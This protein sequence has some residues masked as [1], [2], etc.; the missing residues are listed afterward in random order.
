MVEG[1]SLRCP[2][3]VSFIRFFKAVTK[4]G[5]SMP[6]KAWDPAGLASYGT[7]D[8]LT[9]RKRGVFSQKKRTLFVERLVSG[10]FRHAEV[11][12]GRVCMAASRA[13]ALVFVKIFIIRW[14]LRLVSVEDMLSVFWR[15]T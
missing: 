6:F 10:R 14:G 5:S 13:P 8:T 9:W 12:H 4:P 1:E 11:K 7:A 2:R 15:A 3:Y